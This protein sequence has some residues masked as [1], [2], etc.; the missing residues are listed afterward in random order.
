MKHLHA[1]HQ[2]HKHDGH[3]RIALWRWWLN[4][5]NIDRRAYPAPEP[6]IWTERANGYRA[7]FRGQLVYVRQMAR[8]WLWTWSHLG[9]N[10]G[11]ATAALAIDNAERELVNLAPK[12]ITT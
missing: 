3:D 2:P 7:E 4:K 8:G 5:P 11:F 10:G 6:L 9:G 12:T 1:Y